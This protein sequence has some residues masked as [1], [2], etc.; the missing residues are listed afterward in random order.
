LEK[1]SDVDWKVG[2]DSVKIYLVWLRGRTCFEPFNVIGWMRND[3]KPW[4]VAKNFSKSC[5]LDL[6]VWNFKILTN[7]TKL[8]ASLKL[9][10]LA[11]YRP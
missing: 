4:D 10:S 8:N 11:K 9:N 2:H 1:N 3:H 6:Q 5:G 7:A